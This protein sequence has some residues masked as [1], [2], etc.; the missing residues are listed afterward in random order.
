[1]YEILNHPTFIKNLFYGFYMH[2]LGIEGKTIEQ[3]RKE[4]NLKQR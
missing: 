1:M 2:Q 3:I 4:N